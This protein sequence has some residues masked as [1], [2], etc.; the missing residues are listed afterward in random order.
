[1][2]NT[3]FSRLRHILS[4]SGVCIKQQQRHNSF[5][6]RGG[7]RQS[8]KQVASGFLSEIIVVDNSNNYEWFYV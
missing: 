3:G 6:S 2:I 7:N 4:R 1:M 5:L 8:D